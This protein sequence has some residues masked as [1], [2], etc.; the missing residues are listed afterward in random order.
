MLGTISLILSII[1]ITLGF[2]ANQI[3]KR[4]MRNALG[5]EIK[6]HD[7]TSINTWIEVAE[8]EDRRRS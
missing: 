3:R 5:R 2:I 8:N 1:V 4:R 7:L 6:S